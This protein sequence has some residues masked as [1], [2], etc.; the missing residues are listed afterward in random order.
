MPLVILDRDGV[1]NEDSADYIRGVADWRPLPG[2]IEAI[3]DLS[4]A[5]FHIAIATNQSGLSRGY[6]GL[7]ELEEIH[8][9]LRQQVADLGGE[10]DGI[11]YCP[12]VPDEGCDCRKPATGLLQA[13]EEELQESVKDA[14]FI[15]DSLQ[16]LQAARTM[17]CKP[18]LVLSGKGEKTRDAL[19]IPGVALTDPGLVPIFDDLAAAARAILND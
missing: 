12:H 16:D 8:A 9:L 5:G 10:I 13:I 17:S 11:F 19:Q 3:A 18:A 7:D 2:S 14:Y 6:F 1:I 4:R 15:G